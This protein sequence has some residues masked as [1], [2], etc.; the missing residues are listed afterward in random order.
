MTTKK[1]PGGRPTK[2]KKEYCE[3]LVEHM[4]QGY[5]FESFGASPV[6]VDKVT[7]YRWVE[8][9]AEFSNA[10]KRA[11]TECLKFWEKIGI[12]GALGK[13]QGFNAASFIF[14]MKN[15]FFWRDRLEPTTT[16]TNNITKDSK[17]EKDN[18]PTY[19][20]E[21]GK[22]GKFKSQKPKKVSGA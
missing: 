10:K 7:L 3:M 2:Y 22:D 4:K 18:V 15:R 1:G 8:K 20:V 17:V 9:H 16:I 14:N 19:I 21:V 5:S 13:I 6:C 12:A 11:E